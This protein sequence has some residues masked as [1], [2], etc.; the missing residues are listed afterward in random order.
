MRLLDWRPS[1]KSALIAD[2]LRDR[3]GCLV[4]VGVNVGETLLDLRATSSR[5]Y[6]GVEANPASAAYVQELIDAN[7]WTDTTI[8]GVA[9]GAE[10][11]IVPLLRTPHDAIDS[12]GSVLPSLRP[13]RKT[14]TTHVPSLPF[15]VVWRALGEP[16]IGAVKIDVEGAELEVLRGMDDVL[17]TRTPVI[18]EVLFTDRHASLDDSRRRHQAILGLLAPHRYRVQQIV[19]SPDG[20]RV[21]RLEPIT[22]FPVAY[23]TEEN[24][25]FCDYLFTPTEETGQPATGIP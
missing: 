15:C 8:V 22:E 13:E 4:D 11:G 23:W 16:A 25:E 2:L 6:L 12:S 14:R 24:K 17:A 20:G 10:P 1:W 3:P 9:L 7:G 21:E 5:G 18:C 19:K